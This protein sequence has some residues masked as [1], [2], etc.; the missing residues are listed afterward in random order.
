[1]FLESRYHK[2]PRGDFTVP[3]FSLHPMAHM[4]RGS[5]SYFLSGASFP[6]PNTIVAKSAAWKWW[7]HFFLLERFYLDESAHI[8]R[9][10]SA[11]LHNVSFITILS[12][13]SFFLFYLILR[14]RYN[15]IS[16]LSAFNCFGEVMTWAL[17][18]F[19]SINSSDFA[20][21]FRLIPQL[22][23]SQRQ[24]VELS[25]SG[26]WPGDGKEFAIW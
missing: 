7:K 1:M 13:S 9:N 2:S 19:E 26:K 15:Y 14:K 18:V 10:N 3:C 20:I 21:L 24:T 4:L 16:P 8:F 6:H 25:P 11:P 23:A 12:V 22:T 5:A 17:N